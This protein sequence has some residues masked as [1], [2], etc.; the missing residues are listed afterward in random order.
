MSCPQDPTPADGGTKLAP[1]VPALAVAA[2]VLLGPVRHAGLVGDDWEHLSLAMRPWGSILTSPLSYHFIP[3][4]AAAHKLVYGIAGL[5]GL[6]WALANA[7]ALFLAA[8]SV[9]WLSLR[10]FRDGTA[11]LL[12]AGLLLGSSAFHEVTFWPT[13]GIV[14]SL[15]GVLFVAALGIAFR[16]PEDGGSAFGPIAFAVAVGAAC[17]T[18]PAAVTVVPT[19]I[20]WFAAKRGLPAW[21]GRAGLRPFVRSLASAF[22]PSLPVLGALAAARWHFSTE[23][24]AATRLGFDPERLKYLSEGIAS[25]FSLQGSRAT[26][27]SIV[28][29]GVAP[30]GGS[31]LS[32]VLSVCFLA[33]AA[34]FAV[35]VVRTLPGTGEAFL[36][37]AF[38]VHF[39]AMAP[40]IPVSP[41]HCFL[42]SLIGLPLAVRLVRRLAEAFQR[43]G[44]HAHPGVGPAAAVFVSVAALLAAR[45]PFLEAAGLWARSARAYTELGRLVAERRVAQ[46]GLTTLTTVD[47]PSFV[48]EDGFTVPWASYNLPRYVSLLGGGI[49][50]E[51][52]R[53]RPER[54]GMDW[55]SKVAPATLRLVQEMTLDSSRLVVRFDPGSGSLVRLS[56]EGL[57]LPDAVTADRVPELGWRDGAWPWLLVAPGDDLD[58]LMASPPG[59]WLA[60]RYLGEASS[61]FDVEV[62]GVPSIQ[63]RPAPGTPSGWRTAV[64]SLPSSIG[65]VGARGVA[66]RLRPTAPVA[67]AGV[68]S[69]LPSDRISPASAP[70]LGW[71]GP[72][73]AAS[74]EVDGQL[75]LPLRR[76]ATQAAGPGRITLSVL[77]SPRHSGR[78]ETEGQSVAVGGSEESE[79]RWSEQSLAA[80]VGDLTVLRFR[81][82]GPE[83]LRVRA[84]RFAAD[85]ARG[86]ASLPAAPPGSR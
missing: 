28:T 6:R 77:L 80:G 66:V 71:F 51:R 57:T 53:L 48:T 8:V 14:F 74:F 81:S 18:Y 82:E 47:L 1:L 20:L 5:D 69:F 78:L 44:S 26:L 61:S 37:T 21:G 50:V 85:P 16:L 4:G 68:W 13:V 39:A 19:A 43:R 55:G 62:D 11:A 15:S 25:V 2:L 23:L 76:R 84:I 41:R 73:D 3:L 72:P 58:V 12:A 79:A 35:A 52:L 83:P 59:G 36:A 34:S 56:P 33:L 60:L 32:R 49:Q 75:A 17:L 45:G 65:P 42:P 22:G 67:L 70:F 10:L 7:A 31:D 40:W 29:G 27:H 63:V 38:V 46:P 64:C 86:E 54:A 9:L 24:A 30:D